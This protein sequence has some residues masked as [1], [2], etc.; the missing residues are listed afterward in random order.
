MVDAGIHAAGVTFAITG[1]IVV[2]VLAAM[3]RQIPVTLGVLVY[4]LALMATLAVSALYNLT[5]VS[6][7]K[8]WLRRL[9]H[10]TIFLLIAGTP[11]PFVNADQALE[12]A[13][14]WSLALGAATAK[15][16]MPRRAETWFIGAYL[17]L[18]WMAFALFAGGISS[19]SD[20]TV[21]LIVVGGLLYSVG[22][23]FHLWDNLR[24]HNAI[25]HGF[26]LAAA[27]CH[28]AAVLEGV[29]LAPAV[30]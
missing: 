14:F 21:A 22:V 15:L 28:Y 26:V 10:A 4:A 25:W 6:P 18:G 9:D 23:V 12:L 27:G 19:V 3:E 17:L 30:I 24:F 8:E 1:G 2:V 20:V 7:R 16:L 5:P 11:T 29:V 13:L